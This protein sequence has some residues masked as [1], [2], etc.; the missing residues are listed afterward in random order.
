M[1]TNVRRGKC[2]SYA[3]KAGIKPQRGKKHMN[4]NVSCI[5]AVY[6]RFLVNITFIVGI[7][8]VNLRLVSAAVG[9]RL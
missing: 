8:K 2:S 3:R 7:I 4:M 9:L 5:Y 1:I 6:C